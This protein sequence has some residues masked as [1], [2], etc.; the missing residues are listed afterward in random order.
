MLLHLAGIVL[1]NRV[2]RIDNGLRRAVVLLQFEYLCHR[3]VAAEVED[4]LNL[5][6]AERVDTLRIIAH[7]T[8]SVVE[9]REAA[10]NQI[11]SIVCILILIDKDILEEVLIC[12]KHL[13][14]ISE[15]NI[16][17][18]QQIVKIHRVIVLTT[19][20]IL[21]INISKFRHLTAAI[22]ASQ[23]CICSICSRGDKAVFCSRDTRMNGI[24][25]IL[26]LIQIALLN[27]SLDK[28]ARICGLVD[29]KLTL[30]AYRL[31][32][33]AQY[34]GKNRVEST[35]RYTTRGATDHSFNT[36][37]HLICRLLGKGQREDILRANTLLKHICDARGKHTRLTR[38]R[39]GNNQR[40]GR[41]VY[42]RLFLSRIK[43]FKYFAHSVTLF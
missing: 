27:N 14:T 6:T 4:I 41:I 15:Q 42:Y 26:I 3:V 24:W 17:L 9:L 16:C 13:G 11:L 20:A 40:W 31:G 38:A 37:T 10:N 36:L 32:I 30:V 43:S 21:D 22:I 39:T 5:S 18:Q 35:H 12:R 2:G 1:D 34:T 8:D 28:V 23:R 29:C 19:T 25:L 33:I 7:H